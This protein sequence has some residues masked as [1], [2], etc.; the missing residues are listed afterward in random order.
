[1]DLQ[2]FITPDDDP[3]SLTAA[4]IHHDLQDMA[5][6]DV[7]EFTLPD[8]T[9]AVR[10]TRHD[11]RL[12]EVGETW[13][14]RNGYVYQLS[15]SAPNRAFQD[16]WLREITEKLRFEDDGAGVVAAQPYAYRSSHSAAARPP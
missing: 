2:L 4:R 11:P 1:M 15:V 6:N 8:D 9:P 14:R 13:F 7:I 5:M 12:G 16:A 10:S 3:A